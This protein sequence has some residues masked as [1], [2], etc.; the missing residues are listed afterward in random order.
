MPFVILP[1]ES[2]KREKKEIASE[3]LSMEGVKSARKKTVEDEEREKEGNVKHF[4]R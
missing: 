3:R 2:M 1:N 4:C